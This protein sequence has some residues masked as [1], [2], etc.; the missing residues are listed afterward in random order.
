MNRRSIFGVL[1]LLLLVSGSAQAQVMQETSVPIPAAVAQ[2]QPTG[3]LSQR[4]QLT[5]IKNNGEPVYAHVACVPSTATGSS[6][7]GAP[8]TPFRLEFWAKSAEQTYRKIA[9]IPFTETGDCNALQSRWLYPKKKT[10][11]MLLLRFG[12][13]DVGDWMVFTWADGDLTKT[14]IQDIF[15]FSG[16]SEDYYIA[17]RF[18]TVDAQGR[19]AVRVDESDNGKQ[20]TTLH[21]WESGSGFVDPKA[22]WFVIVGSA[23]TKAEA[24]RLLSQHPD[25]GILP[26]L[27]S[28]RYPK[29]APGHYILVI[30]RRRNKQEAVN[31]ATAYKRYGS[32]S[33][34]KQAF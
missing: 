11:P 29:L 24:R 28:S 4:W 8:R 9:S 32:D 30:A 17:P 27:S 19:L 26:I 5:P 34:A 16:D 10:G 14:P 6:A 7:T 33:Y 12:A 13:G 23:K 31:L 1:V 21:Q 3:N 15:G 22:A 25:W 2:A 20:T 18:D